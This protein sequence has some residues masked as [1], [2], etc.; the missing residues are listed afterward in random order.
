MEKVFVPVRP[1]GT[2]YTVEKLRGK[3]CIVGHDVTHIIISAEGAVSVTYD[4]FGTPATATPSQ[5]GMSVFADP[6]GAIH[7]LESV[8]ERGDAL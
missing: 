3:N 8:T 7:K 6:E 5:L 1:D 2:V 4:Y